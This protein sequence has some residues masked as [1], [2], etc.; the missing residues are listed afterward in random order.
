MINLIISLILTLAAASLPAMQQ[1]DNKPFSQKSPYGALLMEK[2]G[3]HQSELAKHPN[4]I[5]PNAD[6]ASILKHYPKGKVLVFGYGSLMNKTSAARSMKPEAVESMQPVVAF[7][8]KR[9]F[10]YYATKVD[11]WGANPDPKERAMLN[12]APSFDKTAVVNG[13]TLEVDEEDLAN[14][15]KRERGYDLVPI[16]VASWSSV[17]SESTEVEFKV[18]YTFVIPNELRDNIAF[19][20]TQFYPV[21]GYLEA[22]QEGAG[23][24]GKDFLELWDSTTYLADGTTT[25]AKWDKKTFKE[26][27]C[28]KQPK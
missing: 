14:L 15:V 6:Y 25:V 12:L 17:S 20:S 10:N 7:G 16:L 28:T 1:L 13:V 4:L 19:S 18:A 24:F 3:K 2:V 26:I 8:A 11:H 5:Y 22:I 9:I 27:L 23:S 21:R